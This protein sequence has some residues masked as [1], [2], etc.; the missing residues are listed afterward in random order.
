MPEQRNERAPSR[1]KFIR[2]CERIFVGLGLVSALMLS[3]W[4]WPDAAGF[5]AW[6]VLALGVGLAL[7]ASI[8]ADWRLYRRGEFTRRQWVKSLAIHLVGLLLALA[9]AI[10]V[11]AWAGQT[12]GQAAFAA[13][14]KTWVGVAAGLLAGFATGFAAAWLVRSAW[15][16]LFR[17]KEHPAA[18]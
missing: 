7:L 4:L 18:A 13:S 3:C 14:G 12:A 17:P 6:G 15:A 10:L 1:R 2:G 9:V 8:W 16:W 11:G 5:L